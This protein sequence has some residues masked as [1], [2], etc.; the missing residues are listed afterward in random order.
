MAGSKWKYAD[1]SA[2]ER[3]EMLRGGNTE[4]LGE[5][6]ERT[7]EVV[8]AR[9]E[10]GL[11]T[12]AQRDWLDTVGYNYNLSAAPKMGIEPE[13][14]SKSGY[15]RL[16]LGEGSGGAGSS[17]GA[18]SETSSGTSSKGGGMSKVKAYKTTSGIGEVTPIS[19]ARFMVEAALEASNKA[20]DEQYAAMK[21]K[22]K[23]ALFARYPYLDEQI[24][25]SGASL[26]GGKAQRLKKALLGTLDGV[27]AELDSE[28]EKKKAENGGRYRGILDNL[29]AQLRS[30]VSKYELPDVAEKLLSALAKEDGYELSALFPKETVYSADSKTGSALLAEAAKK[31]AQEEA[32]AA[33]ERALPDTA[34][35]VVTSEAQSGA[36]GSSSGLPAGVIPAIL[37]AVGDAFGSSGAGKEA[38]PAPGRK[39]TAGGEAREGVYDENVGE[40]GTFPAF[41]PSYTEEKPAAAASAGEKRTPSTPGEAARMA[42]DILSDCFTGKSSGES[43]IRRSDYRRDLASVLGMLVRLPAKEIAQLSAAAKK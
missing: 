43:A 36:N 22:A 27:Y 17:A 16:Y 26:S 24:V 1:R 41:L 21:E 2:D 3:L 14:V 42:A 8:K 6:I 31:Q 32:E 40:S 9:D 20:L 35:T 18:S 33:R 7:K 23:Q 12:S 15:A 28:L 30:G 5:E 13:N 37:R 11:D 4:L 29:Q 38:D 34:G 39:E 25:N 19:D 10:L